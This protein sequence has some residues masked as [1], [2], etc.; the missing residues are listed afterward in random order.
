MNSSD[1]LVNPE[2]THTP[3]KRPSNDVDLR[4]SDRKISSIISQIIGYACAE[5]NSLEMLV[6]EA[7]ERAEKPWYQRLPEE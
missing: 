3:A 4:R 1:T 2:L 5:A 7:R 6:D